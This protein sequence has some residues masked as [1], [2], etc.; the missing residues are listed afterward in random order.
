[1]KRNKE[2]KE[3]G[4]GENMKEKGELKSKKLQKRHKGGEADGKR[5][6]YRTIWSQK[7]NRRRRRERRYRGEKVAEGEDAT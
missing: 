6:R 4:K 7:V 1:M 3:K 2:G 5:V